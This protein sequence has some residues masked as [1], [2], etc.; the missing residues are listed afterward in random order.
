MGGALH[1]QAAANI[2]M[3]G[4]EE[5]AER[6]EEGGKEGYASGKIRRWHILKWCL[7]ARDAVA[8]PVAS[9]K[10]EAATAATT[11]N[12]T[13][14]SETDGVFIK[15]EPEAEAGVDGGEAGNFSLGGCPV[16]R[17]PPLI[18]I[19]D[20]QISLSRFFLAITHTTLN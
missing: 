11:T 20:I 1:R 12:T 9:L 19:F 6:E 3:L 18:H 15:T 10:E 5:E 16:T 7:A 2:P 17:T 8:N 14:A 13:V 4:E